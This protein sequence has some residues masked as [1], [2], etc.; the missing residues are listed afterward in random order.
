MSLDFASSEN[1]QKRKIEL[2]R[3]PASREKKHKGRFK[4]FPIIE[5]EKDLFSSILSPSG[6]TKGGEGGLVD[7]GDH[8]LQRRRKSW[9][10]RRRRRRKHVFHSPALYQSGFSPLEISPRTHNVK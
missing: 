7:R 6:R 5:R 9:P 4:S 3:R 8:P 10:P 1:A 2:T